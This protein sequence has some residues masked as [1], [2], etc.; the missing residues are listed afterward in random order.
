MSTFYERYNQKMRKIADIGHTLAIMGWD[1]EVNLPKEG[2]AIRSQQMATISAIA[3]NEFTDPK[4]GS[5]LRRL[6]KSKTLD[7]A[8]QKNVTVTLK[9][10]DK[11]TKFD[12]GFVRERSIKISNAYH[13]W[14]EAREANN[15]NL[16][17][18]ALQELIDLKIREAQILGHKGGHPYD[19]MLDQYEPGLTVKT[20]DPIFSKLK[21]DLKPLLEAI[22]N[23]NKVK[24]KFLRKKYAKDKQ[25]AYGLEIL[26]DM[27]YDFDSGRQDISPHPFTTTFGPGDVRV[28]TRISENDMAN[29]LWSC[30]HEGGHALYEQGLPASD[31]GLPTGSAISLSIHES[32]SRLWEN[33][34][35]RSREFWKAHYPEL[36]RR[37]PKNLKKVSL[38]DFYRG[39]NKI[40]PNYIRTEA[41]ELHYHFHVIIRYE[42]EKGLMEGKI[43][44][45]NLKSAWNSKYRRYLGLSSP[46]D[47]NGVLQDVHWAHGSIGYF[48]TYSL[49][50]L[51]AAQFYAQA[52]ND[53]TKLKKKISKGNTKELLDWLQEKIYQHGRRYEA[54]ELCER[55]TGEKLNSDYFMDYARKK[56]GEIYS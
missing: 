43:T 49:G 55:I 22:K 9:E 56:Y 27:G 21:R 10:Y 2:A 1:K 38:E 13:A 44:A 54:E 48:P 5:L 4:F 34:V 7:E 25:W 28:T 40:K 19:A 26:M 32:Q 30:I 14:L 52:K 33:N 18:P 3:H 37:F 11:A 53:I 31:Y 42:I 15:F 24:N 39:A 12:E 41:D 8:Q 20:L 17:K 51:Y 6:D 46:D 45:R 50:S 23:G 29:M 35:G 36:Q 16:Y 47:N